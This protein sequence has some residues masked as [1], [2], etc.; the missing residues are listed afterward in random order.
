M[1]IT[2]NFV[3]RSKVVDLQDF[4]LNSN[5]IYKTQDNEIVE[6]V[7]QLSAGDTIIRQPIDM[8]RQRLLKSIKKGKSLASEAF[9]RYQ[10]DEE[11]VL[12]AI[13]RDRESLQYA[14]DI[15]KDDKEFILKSSIPTVYVL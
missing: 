2:I 4:E 10:D 6:D 9:P 8:E 15:L 13:K 14:S 11:V 5:I 3:G 7:R 12:A 1:S